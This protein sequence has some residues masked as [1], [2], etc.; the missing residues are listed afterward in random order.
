MRGEI[1]RHPRYGA[2]SHGSGGFRAPCGRASPN[3]P[4]PPPKPRSTWTPMCRG[5]KRSP[6]RLSAPKRGS[7]R[8]SKRSSPPASSAAT[9][10]SRRRWNRRPRRSWLRIM[11]GAWPRGSAFESRRP[12]SSP[13]SIR[14]CGARG[15][16]R[17]AILSPTFCAKDRQRAP[18][19]SASFRTAA[20]RMSAPG[21][22]LR[23]ALHLHV[24]YEDQLAGIVERLKLNASAPDLF[25]SV[26]SEGAAERTREALKTYRGQIVDVRA[27]PNFGRDIGPL[28]TQFGP[29]LVRF[30]R[31]HRPPA[32]QEER[33]PGKPV[34][35]GSVE[36]VPAGEFWLAA[37]AAGRC[38]TPSSLPWRP[39]RRSASCF[40]TTR[41]FFPG[42]A[43]EAAPR[44]SRRA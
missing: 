20:P 24:F 23:A 3:A 27:T 32:H 17:A 9:S 14:R 40:P 39:I 22:G 5:S 41:M 6:C 10:S 28:L 30:L 38:S 33:P 34:V 12:A 18:G 7:R 4:A 43:T 29:A 26:T 8:R 16:D 1:S 36:C 44:R 37:S 15:K 11:C 25:I 42:P 19:F 31:R 21:A 2:E 35:R 13:R